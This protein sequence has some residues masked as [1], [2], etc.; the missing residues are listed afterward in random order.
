MKNI[1]LPIIGLLLLTSSVEA[2]FVPRTF[3]GCNRAATVGES[4]L[5]GAANLAAAQGLYLQGL[6]N[7]QIQRQRAIDLSIE[8][9]ESRVRT[10]WEIQDE[11]RKRTKTENYIEKRHRSLDLAEQRHALKQR[12]QDL[13]D[14]GILPPKK[15]GYFIHKGKKFHSIEEWKKSPEY[16][17]MKKEQAEKE[18]KL[19]EEKRLKEIQR[20]KDLEDLRRYRQDPYYFE[21]NRR[22][23]RVREI[24]GEEYWRKFHEMTPEEYERDRMD[25]VYKN[26]IEWLKK[27]G[28]DAEA[29]N[30][31]KF[32][33]RQL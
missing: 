29:E 11:Y 23:E 33:K 30:L 3:W 12:E 18:I 21:K 13:I 6:G 5:N 10:R 22:E 14:K 31:D 9:W 4:Y 15:P 28:R 20:Q 27:Q 2:Q 1:I 24:M 7:Y 26:Q 17:E 32:R 8:N 19:E 25:Y 16:W